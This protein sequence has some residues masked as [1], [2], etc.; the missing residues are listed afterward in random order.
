M[1]QV[2]QRFLAAILLAFPLAAQKFY[3]DDPLPR[4]PRPMPVSKPLNRSINEYYDFF[5]NTFFEPGKEQKHAPGPSQAV[6][7]LGEV[8]DSA[9]YTNRSLSL[10]EMVRG[11]GDAHAPAMDKPWSVISGKNEEKLRLLAVDE[12]HVLK[13]GVR[14]AAIPVFTDAL[15]RRHRHDIFAEFGV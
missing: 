2:Q 14:R 10:A 13:H 15:L 7:T 9:W 4:E 1:G 3:P 12:K 11:P 8:P 6:N 5:Q